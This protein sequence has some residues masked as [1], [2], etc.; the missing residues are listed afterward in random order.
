[1]ISSNTRFDRALVND[2]SDRRSL[3]A[4]RAH[5]RDG[6]GDR[7]PCV[8]RASAMPWPT[9]RFTSLAGLAQP[10]GRARIART[11]V[12]PVFADV[13][14]V[15][16]KR[17]IPA[18]LVRP[19]PRARGRSAASCSSRARGEGLPEAR[20]CAVLSKNI[21]S[22]ETDPVGQSR[23]A[24]RRGTASATGGIVSQG[25]P[26]ASPHAKATS[27]TQIRCSACSMDATRHSMKI[28]PFRRRRPLARVPACLLSYGT[29]W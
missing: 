10:I 9:L 22:S 18:L 21:V 8:A 15:W 27:P 5:S 24:G 20:T 17:S 23:W 13:C 16:M 28:Q 2:F 25:T 1:M 7:S 6:G 3:D 29:R 26:A 12:A 14:P 19:A 4:P 11:I